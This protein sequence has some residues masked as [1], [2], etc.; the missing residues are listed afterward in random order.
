MKFELR[1]QET[2]LRDRI[3]E[4]LDHFHGDLPERYALAWAGY[5]SALSEWGVID[6]YTFSRLYDMLP[7]I[8]EPNPIV[9][10]ALGRTDEEE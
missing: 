6:I 4:D 3:Q 7:P 10:I 1:P 8:A 2:E 9:T 5:L